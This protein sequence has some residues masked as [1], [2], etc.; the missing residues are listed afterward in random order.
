MGGYRFG[1]KLGVEVFSGVVLDFW[2]RSI[3][4]STDV[5]GGTFYGYDTY[6]AVTSLKLGVSLL[7]R[8]NTVGYFLRGGVKAPLLAWQRIDIGDG[9]EVRPGVQM[10][11]FANLDLTFGTLPRDRFVVSFYYDSMNLSKSDPEPL[12][13]NGLPSGNLY[14]PAS[15]SSS[16]GALVI[17]GF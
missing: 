12:T 14:S 15:S 5:L 1:S 11:F 6:N 4:Q 9:V 17:F 7:Q 8:F 13:V 10:S 3:Q 16:L 2:N